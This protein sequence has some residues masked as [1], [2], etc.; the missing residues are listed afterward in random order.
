MRKSFKA[1]YTKAKN[2]GEIVSSLGEASRT[3]AK[4]RKAVPDWHRAVAEIVAAT[5]K[6]G[7]TD[8]ALQGATFALVKQAARLA[9]VALDD[10]RDALVDA[11]RK[12]DRALRRVISNLDT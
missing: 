6:L 9:E 4:P 5:E 1:A 12:A 2:R 7:K 10:D 3:P 8:T 11:L